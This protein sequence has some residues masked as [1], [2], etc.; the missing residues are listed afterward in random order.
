MLTSLRN[1]A[2]T[3]VSIGTP[4]E[5]ALGIRGDQYARTGRNR[6][7]ARLLSRGDACYRNESSPAPPLRAAARST[8]KRALTQPTGASECRAGVAFRRAAMNIERAIVIGIL[9]I[10]F[11]IVVTRFL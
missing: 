3:R 10:V 11:L 8:P 1:R 9:V 7:P 2:Y 6:P 4:L 5:R